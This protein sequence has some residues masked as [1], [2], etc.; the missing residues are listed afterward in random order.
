LQPKKVTPFFAEF[1]KDEYIQTDAI[2]IPK[3][4][5]LDLLILDIEKLEVRLE[6]SESDN[7][8]NLIN[9]CLNLLEQETPLCDTSFNDNEKEI[10]QILAPLSFKPVVVLDN[11]PDVNEIILNALEKS[12]TIFFYTAGKSEVHAWPVK[13]DSD[14]VTCAGK[15]HTDLA[16]GFIK[17]DVANFDEFMQCHNMNDAKTKGVAKVVERDYIIQK[18]DVIEIRFN[19]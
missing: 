4:N 2:V 16:R 19:V 14:I 17:A 1:I 7:E 18:A 12:N 6:R 9:K 3:E 15:I 13:K 8:K 11:I 10:L 5:I